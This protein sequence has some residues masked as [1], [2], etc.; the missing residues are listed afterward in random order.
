MTLEFRKHARNL[1]ARMTSFAAVLAAV[2]VLTP[3]HCV[4]GQN[5]ATSGTITGIITDSTGAVVVGAKVTATN[6]AT[7]LPT[8]TK[9]N[10]AGSFNLPN[11]GIGTYTVRVEQPAFNG[12]ER[13]G[14][15]LDPNSVV[16]VD[17]ALA[18]GN[19]SQTVAVTEQ[20]PLLETQQV[21]LD[22]TIDR[23]FVS[24]LPNVVNGGVRDITALLS[25]SAGVAQ[26]ANDFATNITGGRAF[27][28]E[29][30]LDGV[31]MV[32][33]PLA[34]VALSN[35]PDQEII[36]EVQ[37][38]V[39]VPSAE[40]G[41]ASG[42]VGSFITRSGTDKYHGDSLI[43]LRNTV[44]D[45]TPYNAKSKTQDQ[46]FEWPISVGGP[47]IIPHVYNG[48]EKSFFYFSYAAYRKHSANAPVNATVPTV[49]ER[50]G[51]FSD[52]PG[53]QLYDPATGNLFPAIANEPGCVAGAC[54]PTS[55]FSA[56]SSA[57]L[58]KFIPQPQNSGLVNNYIGGAPNSDLENHYFAR[59]DQRIGNANTIHASFRWDNVN[60]TVPGGAFGPELGAFSEVEGARQLTLADDTIVRPNLVNSASISYSRWIDVATGTPASL[61]PVQI[62]GSYG[63]GFPA[64]GFT[65]TYTGGYGNVSNFDLTH[66]FWNINETLSWE[67]GKHSLKFGARYS[68][69]EAQETN[70]IGDENGVYGFGPLETGHG[71][72]GDGNPFASFLLGEVD[73]ASL[74]EPA[75]VGFSSKYYAVFGQ[76]NWRISP[77]LTA[78]IG[79]RYD[80]QQPYKSPGA[81][82]M[83][84][85]TPNP[86]A[87][88]LPGAIIYTGANGTGDQFMPTWFGGIGPRVGLAWSALPNTVVRAGFGIMYAPH[89][90]SLA[91]TGFPGTNLSPPNPGTPVLQ[92]DTGFTGGQVVP[93]AINTN[94][95][96]LNGQ[97][98]IVTV[99]PASGQSDRLSDTQIVQFDVQHSWKTTLFGAAFVGQY[100]HHI[101]GSNGSDYVL[102]ANINQLPVSDMK[103]GSLLT[104][105]IT[106]PAVEAAGFSAPYPGFTGTLAQALRAF[107]QYQT[108]T[109]DLI[110]IGNS[111]YN[112]LVLRGEKRLS[113]GLQ[114]LAS[115]TISK[116]LTDVS[117]ADYGLPAPQDQYN[118]KFEKSVGS[119][120]VP[121]V[122]VLNY[123]YEL[124][125]GSGK[126]Y[127][128]SGFLGKVLEGFSV[129]AN[130]VYQAGSPIAIAAPANDLPIFDGELHLDRGTGPFT[131]GNRHSV[132][133]A[134]PLYDVSGTTY[135]NQPAF[136]LPPSPTDPAV[137]AN[138]YT[139]L[140]NLKYIL[141]NVRTLGFVNENFS[142]AK[143]QTFH[144]RY[145]FQIGFDMVDAFNRKDFG[146]LNT[147][148]GSP[149]FGQ[150]EGAGDGPRVIQVNS[151]ITF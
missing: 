29:L 103:Y 98:G 104:S 135:L 60:Q 44:L 26:G 6:D 96:Q 121:R 1:G 73:T 66:P 56:T 142:L 106:D 57:F 58:A 71:I 7:G 25:L 40:W 86:G 43:I 124:P 11:L 77:T 50:G 68:D 2:L 39:G 89:E 112:G 101:K 74:T 19:A 144:D 82:V 130:Q 38:Q 108:I 35:K 127:V 113:H 132:K 110:P 54:I 70:S 134:N 117:Q 5:A 125:F 150:Y 13:R 4:W 61:F 3:S 114:F 76:D 131:T 126:S 87:G 94:P 75:P 65:S 115:Y 64:V 9:T 22:Q 139:A 79:L 20:A 116:I 30:L 42:G 31:P 51:N 69:Y 46:Q 138:P 119:G 49:L 52:I 84:Q 136:A 95:S 146:G 111:S 34:S 41:H 149:T 92:W 21:T 91:R 45:A 33:S 100:A 147:T 99:D 48:K 17:A 27:A 36:S 55:R 28:T 24:S 37:V 120:D 47:I 97:G 140:G 123:V 128:N 133:I 67:K 72:T 141:P 148:Y 118:R 129:S 143:R 85:T 105:S 78:N 10:D 88:N 18:V 14:V 32:Y 53:I 81:S 59:V 122:L 80:I 90:Y 93:Y 63:A 83:S 8:E 102:L 151:K 107:P 145:T 15:L 62:P 109:M 16:R 12:L 137:I 23:E